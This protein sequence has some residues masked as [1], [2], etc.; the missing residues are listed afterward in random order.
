V[1]DKA[2]KTQ[3]KQAVEALFDVQVV[4]VRTSK[5]PPSPSAAASPP[6]APGPGRRP[7]CRCVPAT[8]PDLPGPRGDL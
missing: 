3:I 8:H 5:V 2:H 6:V 7:W 4:E 1:H